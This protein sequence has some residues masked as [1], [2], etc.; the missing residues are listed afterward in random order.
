MEILLAE[1]VLR[2]RL[3]SGPALFRGRRVQELHLQRRDDGP[4]DLVLHREDVGDLPVVGLRPEVVTVAGVH[5]LGGDADLIAGLA[6]ASLEH[7]CDV[8]LL[9]DGAHVLVLALEGKG[10]GAGRYPEIRHLGEE[11]EQ[12]LGKPVGEVLLLLVGA[13][14][15]EGEHGDGSS[16]GRA[17]RRGRRFGRAGPMHEVPDDDRRGG[18]E[19]DDGKDHS[20]AGPAQRARRRPFDTAGIDVED[21]RQRHHHREAA[22]Q[23]RH[24]VG[25]HRLGP[26]EA[27]HD[28][29]DDLEHRECGDAIADQRSENAPALQLCHKRDSHLHRMAKH[30]A[31]NSRLQPESLGDGR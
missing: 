4:R 10:R 3:G 12:L 18:E 2:V 29:L 5:E 6:D 14:V 1:Q 11:I 24:D 15:H 17:P 27:V 31:R 28:G 26:V 20:R 23:T 21:P 8:E 25:E 19:G 13:E 16:R 7:G 9:R 30:S 22:C